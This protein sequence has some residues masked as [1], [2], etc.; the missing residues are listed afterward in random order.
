MARKNKDSDTGIKTAADER[1]DELSR[2]TIEELHTEFLKAKKNELGSKKQ[3][4]NDHT[5]TALKDKIKEY[6]S[7]NETDEMKKMKEDLKAA[8]AAVDEDIKDDIEDKK[9]LESGYNG[10]IKEFVKE[11]KNILKIIGQRENY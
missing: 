10:Q 6:R 1:I 7:T 9:A 3:K 8:K 2:M 11:Q 4:K 5:L